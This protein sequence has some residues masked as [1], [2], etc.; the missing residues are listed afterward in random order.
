MPL[1][2]SG[3]LIERDYGKA[4]GMTLE[5]RDRYFPDGI[6]PGKENDDLIKERAIQAIEAIKEQYPDKRVLLVAHGGLIKV[7]L[8]ALSN[9]EIETHS[10]KLVNTSIS[11]IEFS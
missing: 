5:E 2:E 1:V 6:I 11:H 4:S 7:I 9:G 8:K 10:F 3:L